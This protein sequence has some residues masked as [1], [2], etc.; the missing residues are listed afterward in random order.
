MSFLDW[1]GSSRALLVL[2]FSLAGFNSS[3]ALAGFRSSV[4]VANCNGTCLGLDFDLFRV[5]LVDALTGDLPLVSSS[6]SAAGLASSSAT[7]GVNKDF[8]LSDLLLTSDCVA[9]PNGLMDGVRKVSGL[10]S[11]R[12][13]E[14][15]A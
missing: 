9:I 1:I 5:F 2:F 15:A 10:S 14:L 11:A 4:C 13:L 8:A 6:S 3:V 12:E 7:A